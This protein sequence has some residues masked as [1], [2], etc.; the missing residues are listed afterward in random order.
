MVGGGGRA[1]VAEGF[2]GTRSLWEL[3]VPTNSLLE[4]VVSAVVFSSDVGSEDV[5]RIDFDLKLKRNIPNVNS[6]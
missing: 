6:P 1:T 3:L 5:K 4:E 2:V